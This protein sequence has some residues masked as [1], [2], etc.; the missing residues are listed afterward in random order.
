VKA[1]EV[2]AGLLDSNGIPLPGLWHDSLHV[3][4]QV[5]ACIPGS[6]LGPT[7]DNEYWKTLPFC[8]NGSY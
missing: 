1:M 5:T 8:V 2:T 6:A 3:T 4:C 7:L